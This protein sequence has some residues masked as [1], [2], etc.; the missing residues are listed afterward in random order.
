[1]LPPRDFIK[2]QISYCKKLFIK[3]GRFLVLQVVFLQ[4]I[5]ELKMQGMFVFV[6][7]WREGI[8]L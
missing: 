7:L 2:Q 5:D 6:F 8:I 3:P 4:W 1:M